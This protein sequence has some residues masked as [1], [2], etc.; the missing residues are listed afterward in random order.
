[1]ARVVVVG[2]G[3]GGIATAV[4]AARAGHR[5]LLLE[6]A[7]ELGGTLRRRHHDGFGWDPGPGTTS[8]PAVL[9]DLF[10]WS[11]RPLERELDLVPV[12]PGRRH[13]L[14]DGTVLDLPMGSRA[15][16]VAAVEGALGAGAGVAWRDWVDGFAPMWDELRTRLLEVPF[17]GRA[18]KDTRR[19]LPR[20]P[21]TRQLRRLR[22]ERLHPLVL[23]RLRLDGQDPRRVPAAV[24]AS[25]Y[26][27]RTFGRWSVEGGLPALLA[28]LV[29]RV[30]ERGIEVRTGT[31]AVRPRVVGGRATGVELADGSVVEADAVV[32][33]A[34]PRALA[35]W[36]PSVGRTVPAIPAAATHL[37]LRRDATDHAGAPVRLPD[38]PVETVWHGDP[39]LVLRTGGDAP[40][41]HV[42]WT[43]R[44]RGAGED[45]LVALV[46]RGLDLRPHV[47]TRLDLSATEQVTADGCSPLGV[48]WQGWRT[49]EQR[50]RPDSGVPGLHCVGA[51]AHPGA[52]L[53]LTGLGAAQAATLLGTVPRVG[54]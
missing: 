53:V 38:L 33:A 18:D 8:A 17:A 27:E 30:A 4:R 36:L 24:A 52:G 51:S 9:R 14:D 15:D 35:P 5:V 22:D 32:W 40:P 23:D 31:V 12:A 39:L 37:G 21:V 34:D 43:L 29:G 13:V 2:G 26:V 49:L 10:R 44:H 46:R 3:F 25:H 6:R 7:D 16:Q 28:A 41:G 48:A 42:A 11:G 50:A 1:M 45:P 20:R 19:A 47:V 54:S